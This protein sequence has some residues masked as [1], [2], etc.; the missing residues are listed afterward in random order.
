MSGLSTKIL[1]KTMLD[2]V[3]R[4]RVVYSV[5]RRMRFAL[6]S[7]LGARAVPGLSGCVHYNDFMLTSPGQAHVDS[8]RAG[9]LAV[10]DLLDESLAAAGR[11]LAST[12]AVL[13]VGCGYGRIIRELR[14]RI[15]AD[16]LYVNDV[17]DEGARFTAAEFGA[18]QIPVVE[19]AGPEWNGRF[20]LSYLLSVYT[21]LRADMI[22]D[23]LRR[24]ADLLQPGGVLF[25]ATHGQ[26]SAETA[27]RYEQYWLDKRKAIDGLA[28]TGYYYERYPLLLFGIRA[29]VDD[30]PL[31]RT[32]RRIRGAGAGGRVMAAD[33]RRQPSGFIRLA[34]A[35]GVSRAGRLPIPRSCPRMPVH[36]PRSRPLAHDRQR[37]GRRADPASD[38][39]HQRQA[40]RPRC[41]SWRRSPETAPSGRP[42]CT[43]GR[44]A[45][46]AESGREI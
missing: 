25:F 2:N 41:Q 13:E 11:D 4:N 24:V 33:G 18:R 3:K 6:G 39:H 46:P 30:A 29:D 16:R 15:P 37:G 34:Q 42:A 38:R 31:C 10:V 8:Y 35:A 44:S 45:R 1:P 9:A 19:Q 32:S 36:R 23:N 28:E 17:I 26:G 7:R 20:D 12:K 14:D 27:E 5:G 40:F 43:P 21:H 22:E